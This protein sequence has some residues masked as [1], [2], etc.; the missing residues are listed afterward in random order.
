VA[1]EAGVSVVTVSRVLNGTY[2]S[3][4]GEATREK[5]LRVAR[6][7]NYRPSPI[8]R[9][10]RKGRTMLVGVIVPALTG[11]FTAETVQG[12][13]DQAESK[14]FSILLYTTDY[15]PEK[16]EK[17]IRL[18]WEKRVDGILCFNPTQSHR[19]L[20][21]KIIDSGTPIVQMFFDDP[22]LNAPAVVVDQWQGSRLAVNHLIELGHRRI[23]HLSAAEFDAHGAIREKA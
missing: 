10:L 8:A 11:S 22:S 4:V 19:E 13:Q 6:E 12:I 17:F 16:F 14:D 20:M 3:K 18:L 2:P 5:V 7:L 21:E 15:N 1:R 9:G 23:L